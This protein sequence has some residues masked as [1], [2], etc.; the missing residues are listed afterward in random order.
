MCVRMLC[1]II[2]I[3]FRHKIY[4]HLL[5]EVTKIKPIVEPNIVSIV[6]H[7]DLTVDARVALPCSRQ[8]YHVII[9]TISPH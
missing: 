5:C 9:I 8:P 4:C 2:N 1:S 7:C 3:T 6:G